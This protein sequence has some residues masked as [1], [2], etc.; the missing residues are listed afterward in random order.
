[1]APVIYRL[2]GDKAGL[3]DAV[4]EQTLAEFVADKASRAVGP[5]PVADLCSAWDDYI[6]FNLANP[7]VFR[8]MVSRLDDPSK[9]ASA[10][11]AVLA[12]RVRRVAAAGR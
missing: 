4:V 9:T 1:Q 6:A 5:D 7:A 12:E 8:L 10:G 11:L 3:L 2:F